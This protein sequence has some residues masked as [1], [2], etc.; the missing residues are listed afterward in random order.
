MR[1]LISVPLASAFVLVA[2]GSFAVSLTL[3]AKTQPAEDSSVQVDRT[4]K[5]DRLAIAGYPR[6][7]SVPRV[8]T[9]RVRPQPKP[10][11]ET[12]VGCDPLFSPISAP[13]LAH[14]YRRCLT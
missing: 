3:Q 13:A 1:R 6:D 14:L 2:V 5:G 9:E 11:R 7:G 8:N 12:P 4:L 10:S